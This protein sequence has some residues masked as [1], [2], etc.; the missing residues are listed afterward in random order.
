[1]YRFGKT[2]AGI[3]GSIGF[4]WWAFAGLFR[5][6]S[7]VA[8][9]DISSLSDFFQ[10]T[11]VLGFASIIYAW[12]TIPIVTEAES[13]PKPKMIVDRPRIVSAIGTLLIVL[14]I[15]GLLA[16]VYVGSLIELNSRNLIVLASLGLGAVI[17][18]GMGIGI[19]AGFN[20]VRIAYFFIAP[21][22]ILITLA[23]GRFSSTSVIQIMMFGVAAYCLS[24]PAAVAYFHGGTAHNSATKGG[25]N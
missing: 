19:L 11:Y 5:I 24:H 7:F 9:F 21:A 22:C 8:E 3:V 17:Q 25:I 10:I 4:F 13:T 6:V 14:S 20:W 2:R 16:L 12:A 1:M 15:I 18:V 23:F